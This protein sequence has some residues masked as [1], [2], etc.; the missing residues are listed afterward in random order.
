MSELTPHQ[1]AAL[2][3]LEERRMEEFRAKHGAGFSR[4]DIERMMQEV[5]SAETEPQKEAARTSSLWASIVGY[6]RISPARFA[7]V[8]GAAAVLVIAVILI[9]PPSRSPEI[10]MAAL[11]DS[12]RTGAVVLPKNLKL[13]LKGRRLELS[14]GADR[15]VGSIEPLAAESSPG[16]AAFNVTLSGKDTTGTEGRFQGKLWLTNTAGVTVVGKQADV[17]GARMRGSFEI[18]GKGSNAVEQVFVPNRP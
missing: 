16:V 9:L 17:A 3:K 12:E 1:V 13:D 7:Y 14:E 8:A 11:P 6:F 18:T 15:L 2:R 10:L 5:E 4:A